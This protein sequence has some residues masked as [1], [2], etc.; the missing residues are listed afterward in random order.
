MIVSLEGLPGA[1]KTTTAKLLAERRGGSYIH[2]SSAQH[3]FLDAFYSDIE[4]YKFETELCFVLLHYHQY[5]DLERDTEDL[6]ILDYSPIKD[7]VF[8]DLNL[9]GEDYDLFSA[10]YGRTSGSLAL[11]DVAVFLDLELKDT[12]QR[13]RERGR[14][15][16]Q[17]IDPEYLERLGGAYEARYMQLGS[18]VERVEVQAGWTREDVCQAVLDVL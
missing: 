17:N 3:P 15:Y 16:E 6:V 2:E 8:A 1:G 10:L 14:P 7:L 18:R 9:T 5:R 11:P 13:I 4:R 12:L